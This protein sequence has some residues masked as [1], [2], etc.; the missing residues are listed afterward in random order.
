M[1]PQAVSRPLT[2]QQVRRKR[3]SAGVARLAAALGYGHALQ[4]PGWTA[5]P[6]NPAEARGCVLPEGRRQGNQTW[7]G[8]KS[9]ESRQPTELTEIHA[10]LSLYE[11]VC[12][13]LS[14]FVKY[15]LLPLH[16]TRRSYL[17]KSAF[18]QPLLP[19]NA[20]SSS[21]KRKNA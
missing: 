10:L 11:F 5:K 18:D 3:H 9:P 6:E 13:G 17:P 2:E 1:G 21:K 8:V 20:H 16:L 15:R 19:R 4:D 7:L 12:S 14:S